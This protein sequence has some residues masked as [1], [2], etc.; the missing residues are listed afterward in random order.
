[1]LQNKV[2]KQ[3]HLIKVYAKPLKHMSQPFDRHIKTAEQR[4]II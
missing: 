2:K 4:T 3:Q 1:M